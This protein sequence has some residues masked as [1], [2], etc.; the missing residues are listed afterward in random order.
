MPKNLVVGN[1]KMN[2]VSLAEFERYLDM[3][4]KETKGKEKSSPKI[5]S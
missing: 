5:P 1:M 2:P 4:E 3:L